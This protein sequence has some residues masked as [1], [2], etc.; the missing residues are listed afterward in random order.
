[1]PKAK[2]PTPKKATKPQRLELLSGRPLEGE[3]NPA[4]SAC[5][6]FL[7]MGIGRSLGG[8]LRIYIAPRPKNPPKPTGTHR[9]TDSSAFVGVVSR[10]PPTQS[11]DTLKEWSTKYGWGERAALFDLAWEEEK[12]A[13]RRAVFEDGYG[14]DFERAQGLKDLAALLKAQIFETSTPYGQSDDE[15]DEDPFCSIPG[16]RARQYHNVWVAD[17]KSIGSGEFA[18]R[19]D[20]EKFNGAILSEYRALLTEIAQETGGR[21]PSAQVEAFLKS[22]QKRLDYTR[23]SPAQIERVSRGEHP[24]VV[25]LE[26]FLLSDN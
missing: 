17:V 11:L 3:S 6:D 20:L 15:D 26:Q 13:R 5:N 4:I 7:G 10:V 22:V 18:E 24:I 21:R 16:S 14:L 2:T 25:L 23:M 19:V 1:M 9:E 12:E 8:L